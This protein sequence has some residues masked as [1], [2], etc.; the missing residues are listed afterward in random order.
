MQFFPGT[1]EAWYRS[2]KEKILRIVEDI[3][4]NSKLPT[5]IQKD[6]D[7]EKLILVLEFI[8]DV[9]A[10]ERKAVI[11]DILYSPKAVGERRFKNRRELEKIIQT[12]E[13]ILQSPREDLRLFE[14]IPTPIYGA[15]EI[16]YYNPLYRN[17]KQV[18]LNDG[19]NIKFIDALMYRVNFIECKSDKVI[20]TTFDLEKLIELKVDKKMNSILIGLGEEIPRSA[21]YLLR[22]LSLELN[23]PIYILTE[24]TPQT[25]LNVINLIK[26]PMEPLPLYLQ[27]FSV[28]HALWVGVSLEDIPENV[29]TTPLNTE[30]KTKLNQLLKMPFTKNQ[31]FKKEITLMQSKQIKLTLEEAE[32]I[33]ILEYLSGRVP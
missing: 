13:V 6:M 22:R 4:K 16:E 30:D 19:N 7:V 20:A 2:V 3:K 23:L 31:P 8:L 29:K 24:N 27:K 12:I 17:Q 18:K 21:R 28:P 5:G 26:G 9:L 14:D 15:L 10:V 32:K 33:N 11:E 25:L 1:E